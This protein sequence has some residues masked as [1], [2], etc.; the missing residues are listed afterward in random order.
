MTERDF[1]LV[2]A[3]LAHPTRRRMLDLLRAAPG[4][5]IAALAQHF[6]MSA[7]GVLK[8]VKALERAGLVVSRQAGR[9]R[10]LY[11]NAMPLQLISDRW[12]DDYGAF[13]TGRIADLKERLESVPSAEKREKRIA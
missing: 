3:A 12:T 10:L 13:W 11:F 6:K 5:P 2:F 7:V 1:D 9:S 4:A 8:H